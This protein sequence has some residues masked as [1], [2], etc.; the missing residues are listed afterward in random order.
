MEIYDVKN[1]ILS[2]IEGKNV[3]E[4]AFEITESEKKELN[5]ELTE[6]SLYRTIF[7]SEV[8]VML[9]QD[10]KKGN[11]SG[12]DFSVEGL[13]KVVEDAFASMQS[14]PADAANQIAE[15]Q[16]KEVFHT[17]PYEAD[18]E[19]FYDRLEEFLDT[20]KAEYPK[21]MALQL[22][23]DHTKTHKLYVNSG[24]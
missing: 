3:K 13:T 2:L 14:S 19:T 17:G 8:S 12:S 11:S 1:Q 20:I 9:L 5:T 7:D 24:V 23:A 4:F 15:K 21:V 18:M 22:I 16:E 6:F 10:G